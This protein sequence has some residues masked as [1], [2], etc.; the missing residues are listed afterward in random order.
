MWGV[1]R[2][3][4]LNLFIDMRLNMAIIS[5]FRTTSELIGVTNHRYRGHQTSFLTLNDFASFIH[6]SSNFESWNIHLWCFIWNFRH[7]LFIDMGL[8]IAT[9]V[10]L[11]ASCE[12]IRTNH[13]RSCYQTRFRCFDF[14]TTFIDELSHRSLW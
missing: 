3:F 10:R 4:E 14:F 1:T 5:R 2:H 13:R 6:V 11:R 9:L 12:F 8:N 7:N